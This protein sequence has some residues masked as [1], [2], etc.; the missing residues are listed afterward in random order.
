MVGWWPLSDQSEAEQEFE[1]WPMG[2]EELAKC[3]LANLLS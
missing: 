1:E 3:M 2:D